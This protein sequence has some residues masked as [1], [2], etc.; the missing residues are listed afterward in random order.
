MIESDPN[1]QLFVEED[2]RNDDLRNRLDAR[3][4]LIEWFKRA[5]LSE[6]YALKE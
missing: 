6:K 3:V 1:V 5:S 4:G 2:I